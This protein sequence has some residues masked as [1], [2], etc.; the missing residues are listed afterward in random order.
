M[1]WYENEGH[2]GYD[3]DGNKI[4]RRLKPDDRLGSFVSASDDKSMWRTV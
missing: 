3:L 2:I 4:M 1:Q